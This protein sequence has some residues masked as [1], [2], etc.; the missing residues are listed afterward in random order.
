MAISPRSRG[1]AMEAALGP[2]AQ[3][4]AGGWENK[5]APWPSYGL[6]ALTL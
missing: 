4:S 6:G 5:P 2:L 1:G 3:E